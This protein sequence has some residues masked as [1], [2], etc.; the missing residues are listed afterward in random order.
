MALD[1]IENG[2]GLPRAGDAA[3]N[4]EQIGEGVE[5]FAECAKPEIRQIVLLIDKLPFLGYPPLP[6]QGIAPQ[7]LRAKG[8]RDMREHAAIAA[9]PKQPI[10]LIRHASRLPEKT[11]AF[12][13]SLLRHLSR[14]RPKGDHVK[15]V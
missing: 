1:E 5:P 3:E 4:G 10:H 8:V 9:V 2:A 14:R 6:P 11:F 12:L 13:G 15:G 7:V